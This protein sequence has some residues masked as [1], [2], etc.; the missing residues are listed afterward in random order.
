M[1]ELVIQPPDSGEF[2]FLACRVSYT[3]DDWQTGARH[4]QADIEQH[5]GKTREFF[6]RTFGNL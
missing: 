1:R 3:T 6:E 5:M 2:I 4:L